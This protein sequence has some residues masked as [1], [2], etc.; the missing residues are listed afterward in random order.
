[1]QLRRHEFFRVPGRMLRRQQV[2]AVFRLREDLAD[3]LPKPPVK[4]AAVGAA[5]LG[6]HEAPFVDVGPQPLA[7]LRP[8]VEEGLSREPEDRCLH[9]VGMGGCRCV[10]YVPGE[11]GWIVLVPSTLDV[12]HEMRDVVAVAVPV[13][14]GA[15]PALGHDH[16]P[17][18][19]GEEQQG[20]TGGDDLVLDPAGLELAGEPILGIDEHSGPLAIPVVVADEP[21]G[22]ESPHPLQSV[23]IVVEP[24][25]SPGARIL[26]DGESPPQPV[27]PPFEHLRGAAAAA[28]G[29]GPAGGLGVGRADVFRGDPDAG[30]AGTRHAPGAGGAAG[31]AP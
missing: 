1:M 5:G 22:R 3:K 30:D 10:E 25:V 18:A 11:S 24:G 27:E 12:F 9:Q 15:M 21:P 4:L 31:I 23:E 26:R 14:V 16:R 6:E 28:A 7:G 13:V 20:E 17:A 2:E 19:L 29:N 8:E